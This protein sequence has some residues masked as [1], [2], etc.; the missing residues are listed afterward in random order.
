M[1]LLQRLH[2][3]R[4]DGL[5]RSALFQRK[6]EEAVHRAAHGASQKGVDLL[7]RSLVEAMQ[8]H[9]AAE[10]CRLKPSREALHLFLEACLQHDQVSYTV[11]FL[12]K[13][14][15]ESLREKLIHAYAKAGWV[16]I[17]R[18]AARLRPDRKLTPEEV[19]A[20]IQVNIQSGNMEEALKATRISTTSMEDYERLVDAF[21]ANGREDIAARVARRGVSLP[22]LNRL[23]EVLVARGNAAVALET[24]KL[25]TPDG[26]GDLT[27]EERNDL[28]KNLLARDASLVDL[29]PA[30]EV[31]K[32]GVS[33]DVRERL[34]SHALTFLDEKKGWVERESVM[35]QGVPVFWLD[36]VLQIA[37]QGVSPPLRERLMSLYLQRGY[38]DH[39]F[40]A[41]HQREPGGKGSL[42]PEE[43]H[44]LRTSF[45]LRYF[46]EA[47]ESTRDPTSHSDHL[48]QLIQREMQSQFP[49]VEVIQ[50]AAR[51]RTPEG[52]GYV[53][54]EEME[55]LFRI[56][57]DAGG[58]G[59]WNQERVRQIIHPASFGRLVVKYLEARG[60]PDMFQSLRVGAMPETIDLLVS[61]CTERQMVEEA[62][63][64]AKLR[65][66]DG[67][68]TL[69]PAEVDQMVVHLNREG[70]TREALQAA[71]LG[72]SPDVLDR[73]VQRFIEDG[74]FREGLETARL[75]ATPFAYDMLV[76]YC[77]RRGMLGDALEVARHRKPDGTGTLF[78]EEIDRLVRFAIRERNLPKALQVAYLRKPDGTGTLTPEEINQMAVEFIRA[79]DLESA[80]EVV[81]LG[82][83]AEV[84]ESLIAL[85]IQH[86][87]ALASEIAKL[88]KQDGSGTLTE[89]ELQLLKK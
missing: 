68:G 39:A 84:L 80:F 72:A 70:R 4:V 89:E 31:A 36:V 73:L 52:T 17:A 6:W 11:E 56:F 18:K 1:G 25:R 45:L 82:A 59:P 83:S 65:K 24:A 9:L 22:C 38:V 23:I 48:T 40:R 29:W 34:V 41:A 77:V 88:R 60:F 15:P 86:R 79:G 55:F 61:Y 27:L 46:P 13:T 74:N 5:V 87:S 19:S 8:F 54:L 75:G 26:T 28:V 16:D 69:T 2:E 33:E 76:G 78:P 35:E 63:Q 44:T 7:V 64:A 20:L 50:Q 3:R 37:Q 58:K 57:I 43:L 42:T 71:R 10:A 66:P 30:I 14:V 62:V 85:A 67:T 47:G 21:I 51:L 49:R 81:K 32:F 53:S 12:D